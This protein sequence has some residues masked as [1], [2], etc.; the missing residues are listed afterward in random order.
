MTVAQM[1]AR[2]RELDKQIAD[3]PYWG[4]VLTAWNE[5]RSALKHNLELA[6]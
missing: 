2:I 3:Y 5:E 1:R 4:A 6:R